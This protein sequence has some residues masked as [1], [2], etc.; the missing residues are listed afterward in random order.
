MLDSR[1]LNRK[2]LDGVTLILG[3]APHPKEMFR[4]IAGVLA[5][6]GVVGNQL[7]EERRKRSLKDN[8]PKLTH[9]L[10]K[11]DQ[12]TSW[13][14]HLCTITFKRLDRPGLFSFYLPSIYTSNGLYY[15]TEALY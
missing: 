10:K 4:Q 14:S 8:E 2:L 12:A 9:F 15:L 11:L 1:S 6:S 3:E 7:E 5:L 13:K